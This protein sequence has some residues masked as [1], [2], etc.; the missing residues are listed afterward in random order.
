[1]EENAYNVQFQLRIARNY[2]FLLDIWK[3]IIIWIYS[4]WKAN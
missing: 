2:G 1:M 3:R 4:M